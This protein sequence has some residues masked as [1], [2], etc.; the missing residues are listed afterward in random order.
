MGISIDTLLEGLPKGPEVPAHIV[1]A[2][3]ESSD[4]IL[5]VLDDDPTG[6]QSVA[7]LYHPDDLVVLHHTEV[8]PARQGAGLGAELI[9]AALAAIRERGQRVVP[10]CSYVADFI[11]EHPDYQDLVAP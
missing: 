8:D 9:Q 2:L 6:T 5:V 11:A 1:A 7:D 3:A 10:Q 4:R